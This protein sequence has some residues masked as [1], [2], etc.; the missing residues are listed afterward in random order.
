MPNPTQTEIHAAILSLV[1]DVADVGIVLDRERAA[2]SV[3]ELCRLIMNLN[4]GIAKGWVIRYVGFTQEEGDGQC[5]VIRNLKYS[6]KS[7]YPY[8]DNRDGTDSHA[9]FRLML[10]AV[11]EAFNQDGDRTLGTNNNRVRHQFLQCI[12]DFIVGHSGETADEIL[13]HFADMEL[14][15]ELTN[16]Y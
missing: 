8:R 2:E 3:V 11:N 5:E 14:I 10:E 12:D 7:F 16:S 4:S 1:A 13:V 15:V 9:A 6:L